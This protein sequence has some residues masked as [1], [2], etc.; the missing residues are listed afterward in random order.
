MARMVE[1]SISLFALAAA[2]VV[3]WLMG[4]PPRAVIAVARGF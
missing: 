2:S 4:V 3:V 1:V